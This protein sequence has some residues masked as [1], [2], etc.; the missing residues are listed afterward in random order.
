MWQKRWEMTQKEKERPD[1]EETGVE[2]LGLYS[3]D[4][5]PMTAVR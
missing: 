2:E 3:G 5:S 4:E 1:A